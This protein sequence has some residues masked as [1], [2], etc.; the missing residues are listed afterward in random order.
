MILTFGFVEKFLTN[1][2]SILK[3]ILTVYLFMLLISTR[4]V[5]LLYLMNYNYYSA[6]LHRQ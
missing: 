6:L 3:Q 5:S 2:F 1:I 4:F